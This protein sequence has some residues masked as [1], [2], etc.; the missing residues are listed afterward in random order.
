MDDYPI[1][2]RIEPIARNSRLWAVLA[3]L[4]IK[5]IALIPHFIILAILSIVQFIAFVIAQIVVLVNG[6][7]PPALYDFVT[8]VLRWQLRVGAFFLSLTD[9]YP[10]F[11][12][13]PR[14][15][16]PVDLHASY[17]A[18]SNRLLAGLTVL[19]LV[20]AFAIY[21]VASARN[22]STAWGFNGYGG[23]SNLRAIVQIPHYIVLTF[24]GIAVLVVWFVAQFVILFVGRT[25][26]GIHDFIENFTRWST[27]VSSFAYG[28]TDRY[29]PFSGRPGP[30]EDVPVS[31]QPIAPPG[32][33]VEA[34]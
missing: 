29:P 2:V 23:W 25:G 28:L 21:G 4:T 5:L 14:D 22:G 17:P 18:R 15:D 6:T 11:A 26:E 27:R 10:P 16:Y 7:Y 13:G 33:G 1:A 24:Y 31:Q 9:R 20:I 32:Q 19:V 12:L 3:I 34:A 8:G 30:T